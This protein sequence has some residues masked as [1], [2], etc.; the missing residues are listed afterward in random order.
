M[1]LLNGETDSKFVTRKWNIVNDQS[2]TSYDVGSDAELGRDAANQVTVKNCAP[3]TKCIQK[4][5]GTTIEDAE[6][7]DLV[8]LMYDLLEYSSNYSDK[9]GS[10]WFYPKDEAI[11]FNADITNTDVLSVSSIKLNYW[12]TQLQMERM[13]FSETRLSLCH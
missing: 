6:D 12:Q 9:T 7:L 8:K 4:P 10:S 11:N 2:N 5:D 1:N 13:E 3:F